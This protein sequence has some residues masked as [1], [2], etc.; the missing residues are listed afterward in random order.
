M[1]PTP[2]PP[3]PVPP[4]PAQPTPVPPTPAQPTPVPP[5]PA[6]PTPVQPTPVPPTPVQPT[7][8][9]TQQPCAPLEGPFKFGDCQQS[10]CTAPAKV[11]NPGLYQGVCQHGGSQVTIKENMLLASTECW[12][13]GEQETSMLF[14]SPSSGCANTAQANL[15]LI[16]EESTMTLKG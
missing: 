14:R 9:P 12:P 10:V 5:T 6:Q 1:P 11:P 13:E 4:T 3:T 7:P 16:K 2:V 8:P 15:P